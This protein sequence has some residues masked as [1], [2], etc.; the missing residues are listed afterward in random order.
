MQRPQEET[1]TLDDVVITAE[2][3]RRLP[4]LPNLFLENQAMHTLARLMVNQPE[5]MLKNLVEIALSLCQAGT[6]GVSLLDVTPSGEEVFR[7]DMLA[8]ILEQYV[9]GTTPRNFSPC[10]T[11]LDRGA[12]QLYSYPERYFTYFQATKTPFVEGLVLPLIADRH[13]LGTIWIVSHD[14]ER[15]F[16][17]EDV[18]VMTSLADFTAAALLLNQR[19]TKE[20]VVKNAQ[21][22][23]EVVERQR[24]ETQLLHLAFHDALTGLPNRTL[25]MDR[26]GQTLERAKERGDLFAVFFLDLDRFKVVND[27]LGHTIGDRLLVAIAERLQTCL[28]SGDLL[29]RL[30]GDE[31]AI[32]LK[33][34]KSINDAINLAERLQQELRL[35]FHIHGYEVFTTLSIGIA[36]STT[37]YQQPENLL[38]DADIAM[39]RAK[40][41]GTAR[42]KI[43]DTAMYTE[44]KKLLQI[45]TDLRRAIE[46]QEF[47]IHYQ[48]I[49][50]LSTNKIIGFEALLRW[51]HPERGLVLPTEFIS[52][53]EETGMLIPIGYWVLREACRQL[54]LWQQQFSDNSLT[55]NV[56]LSCKQFSQ[57]HLNEEIYE[58]LQSTHL[59]PRSLKLEIT[60][61]VMMENTI[62]ATAMLWQLKD[63]GIELHMD[64][65]GTGYSS[66]SYLHRFPVSVLKIDRS[67]INSSEKSEIVRAIVTLAH[68]LGMDVIA[69]GIETLE[70][71]EKL[72]ALECKYG[73]GYFFSKP[74]EASAVEALIVKGACASRSQS[75]A[76]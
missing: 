61:S 34:M 10:G 2:L 38:R 3:S 36:L 62:G 52:V 50:S 32:L 46:R 51:Q 19:Q 6:A 49:V 31:F 20:L 60:E 47:R 59:E 9:G 8:G 44:S 45:E 48:P 64:D 74:Q 12:P 14:E 66:L 5:T 1:V 35:P 40:A 70:Q 23:A 26:L 29:A 72:K 71:Q 68:S 73:Q 33:D 56:N 21:L 67:F 63:N 22:E 16:N 18:R 42:Y 55:I 37:G 43:F 69:E 58:I 57:P 54:H 7:W 30:G 76:K 17:L 28:R 39:Y 15:R 41:M 27:S 11:C 13:P 75:H 25:F 4:R 65:F 24:A 53:A